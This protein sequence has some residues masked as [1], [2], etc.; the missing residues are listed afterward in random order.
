MAR[1]VYEIRELMKIGNGCRVVGYTHGVWKVVC[2]EKV[3][4]WDEYLVEATEPEKKVKAKKQKF[5]RAE[6]ESKKYKELQQI[7]KDMG[8]SYR[9]RKAELIERILSASG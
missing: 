3:K 9:G 5:T 6:L 8:I 2:T 4:G 7:A 1:Y